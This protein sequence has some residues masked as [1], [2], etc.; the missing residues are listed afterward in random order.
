MYLLRLF[1]L[2]SMIELCLECA[3][4]LPGD[5]HIRQWKHQGDEEMGVRNI[6][7]ISLRPGCKHLD[8]DS[9]VAVICVR[10]VDTFSVLRTFHVTI[11]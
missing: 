8:F 11:V 7:H 10:S 4:V 5:R 2:I 3:V 1:I 6:L 9:V